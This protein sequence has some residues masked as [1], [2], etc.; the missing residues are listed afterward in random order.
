VTNWDGR[1]YHP[2]RN[3]HYCPRLACCPGR[4]EMVKAEFSAVCSGDGLSKSIDDLTPPQLV[5][6]YE[7]FRAVEGF[8]G[9]AV[10]RI[11]ELALA[12][13]SLQGDGKALVVKERREKEILAKPAWP[14]L[15][16][17]LS[18]DE[19]APCVKIGKT[20]VEQAVADKAPHGQKGRVKKRLLE[21]LEAA[22][23]IKE[24]VTQYVTL[25][26]ALPAHE[27]EVDDGEAD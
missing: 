16:E 5:A 24:T 12:E 10:D 18:N 1:T 27:S 17:H 8:V 19:L 3:C 9:E 25:V 15:K 7:R 4:A 14:V 11:K 26:K 21:E 6:A 22:G 23:A 20:K 13:G 2:G